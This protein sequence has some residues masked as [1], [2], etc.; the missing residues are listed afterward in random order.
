MRHGR[1][2]RLL[3]SPLLSLPERI[4]PLSRSRVL[5]IALCSLTL[6]LG[7]CVHNPLSVF[8]LR[9]ESAADCGD[10]LICYKN[11]CREEPTDPPGC[12]KNAHCPACMQCNVDKQVCE[13]QTCG[14]DADCAGCTNGY[15][16]LKAGGVCKT[17]EKPPKPCQSGDDCETKLC[18]SGR[19][20]SCKEDRDCAS[21]LCVNGTCTACTGDETC[22]NGL[23]CKNGVC[24]PCDNNDECTSKLCVD[25]SCKPCAQNDDCG[26]GRLCKE[27]ICAPCSD[28]SECPSFLCVSGACK[29]CSSNADCGTGDCA[30]GRCS[31]PCSVN[32]DCPSNLCKNSRCVACQEAEDCVDSFR[33]IDGRCASPCRSTADCLTGRFCVSGK[34]QLPSEGEICSPLVGCSKPLSCINESGSTR[35]RQTCNPVAASNNCPSGQLCAYQPS[36]EEGDNG[37]CKLSNNGVKLGQP[38]DEQTKNCEV[39]LFCKSDGKDKLCR[40]LC[41]TGAPQS[42]G[43]KEICVLLDPQRPGVGVCLP[44]ICKGMT[45]NCPIGAQCYKDACRISCDPTKQSTGCSDSTF[46]LGLSAQEGGGGVCLDKQCD[47]GKGTCNVS[48]YCK[49]FQCKPVTPPAKTCSS[50]LD[51][52]STEVCVSTSSTSTTGACRAK[53]DFKKTGA[54]S[55]LTEHVCVPLSRQYNNITAYCMPRRG[56]VD[57]GKACAAGVQLCERTQFCLPITSKRASCYPL[58]TTA[59]SSPSPDAQCPTDYRCLLRLRDS[60]LGVCIKSATLR[61]GDECGPDFGLCPSGSDCFIDDATDKAFCRKTCLSNASCDSNQECKSLKKAIFNAAASGCVAKP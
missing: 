13:T 37:I 40:R 36:D 4:T 18:I 32:K 29:S 24:L 50:H 21:K 35:C 6:L 41:N 22:R 9:C 58:C 15:C 2:R 1:F 59:V 47:G 16:D 42:C 48:N 56:G 44:P 43:D 45:G 14:S 10:G 8:G 52:K 3:I 30:E 55:G 5:A 17:G 34:C 38:C 49:D 7:A 26:D 31:A 39:N 61:V 23:L 12:K 20:L 53:C 28:N 27:K 57:T 46:C 54:C 19:C 33:C 11:F 51:C 25:G 60:S